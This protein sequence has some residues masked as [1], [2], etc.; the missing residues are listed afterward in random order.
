MEIRNSACCGELSNVKK[1]SQE[2]DAA[3]EL[4]AKIYDSENA[5]Y[6]GLMCGSSRTSW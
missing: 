3:D 1:Q 2:S 5:Y 6:S 4:G